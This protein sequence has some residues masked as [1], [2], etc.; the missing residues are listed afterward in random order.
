MTVGTKKMSTFQTS[1]RAKG[2]CTIAHLLVV[3]TGFHL[4]ISQVI[5]SL[6]AI[7]V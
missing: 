7:F 5:C 6:P 3:Y 2:L 1:L 4:G